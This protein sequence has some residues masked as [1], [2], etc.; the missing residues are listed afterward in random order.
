MTYLFGIIVKNT[1][2]SKG[3]KLWLG[4]MLQGGSHNEC[5]ANY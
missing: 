3:T 2:I 5:T 1:E 4:I